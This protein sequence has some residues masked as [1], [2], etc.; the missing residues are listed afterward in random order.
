MNNKN[1]LYT[2]ELVPSFCE[3]ELFFLSSDFLSHSSRVLDN[4]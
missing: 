3:I 4:F 2:C 1:I